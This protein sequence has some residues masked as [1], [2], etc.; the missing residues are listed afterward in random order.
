MLWLPLYGIFYVAMTMYW[1]RVCAREN[2]DFET[3]FSAGHALSP[4]VSALVL[5]GASVSGWAILDASAEVAHAGFG[6]PALLQAGIALALPGVLFFKRIWL[7]GQRLRLSSQSELLR[8]YYGS[9]FL[10]CVSTV[11]AVLLAVAFSGLQLAALSRLVEGLT[12]GEVS[13]TVAA[14]VLG[15]VLFGY[16]VIGGMRI[17]G[18]LGAIQAVLAAASMIGFAGFA[19]ITVG[20]F[21]AL[22]AGLATLSTD[23]L[24]AGRF[25]VSGVIQFTAGAG[26][27]AAAGHEGTALASL[28]IAFALMGFQASPLALK[29]ILSTRSPRA[30]AAGQTWVM[31]GAYG[32]LVALCVGIVGAV[33]LYLPDKSIAGLLGSVSPWFAAWLFVGLL[34]GVQ[35]LAGLGLLTAGEALVRHLYKPW[36]HGNLGRRGTVTLTRVVIGLLALTSVLMQALTPVTLSTLG[37]LALPMSFQLWVPLLGMTWLRW[38]TRPAAVT[39]VGFGI[40]GVLL[41]EPFGITVLSFFGLDVPW[42]RA[43]WTLHSAAWGMMANLAVTLLI[44]AFTQRRG[45]SEEAQEIRRFLATTLRTS[46]RARAL[47]STAWSVSLAWLFLAVGPG[48]VFGNGALLGPDR[49]WLVGMP[50]LWAWSLLFWALGV[51]LVWFLSYKMEMASPLSMEIPAYEPRPKLR[52]H[53][54]SQERDRARALIVTAAV[55]FALI[56]L[57]ALSFGH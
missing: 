19:L 41:T 51:G 56:V 21:G 17:V 10:V 44:S 27:E 16:I 33:S 55:A 40:A 8:G 9:E 43:P 3:Y 28:S 11:V 22:N 12:G 39:G 48:L 24:Q 50:S 20:G 38:I 13:A 45:F 54:E 29:V 6:I 30:I 25:M 2:N 32:G 49:Q 35:L 37:S 4:W 46:S 42:G 7:V 36:F 26:R 5:A 14:T 23:P 1:A 47:R 15:V 34:A 31:A 52:A 53:Q 18:Y 57:T